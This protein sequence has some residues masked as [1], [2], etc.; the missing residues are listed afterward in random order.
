[1]NQ[2]TLDYFGRTTEQMVGWGWKEVLHPDDLP[3]CLER[4]AKA[5]E[6]NT[7]Y[8]IEFRLRR[9]E[10]DSYRWHLGRALPIF[11]QEGQVVKWIGTNTDIMEFKQLEAQIQQTQK[12]EAIG[13]LAG[14]IAH[15]FNNILSAIMGYTEIAGLK[16]GGD[17]VV[18]QNL[19]EVLIASQRAKELVQQILAFSRQGDQL[20]QP[21]ELQVT[22][23][24]VLKFPSRDTTFQH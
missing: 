21:I 7:P 23:K 1:M 6:T 14:G 11:N 15:D 2:R 22:V 19:D 17:K 9:R 8:E 18:K 10:D 12:M 16:V 4:W 5:R 20:H 24:E 13:T 3:L